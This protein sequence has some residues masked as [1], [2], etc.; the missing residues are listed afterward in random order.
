MARVT[1]EE[2]DR[3]R[4]QAK[5]RQRRNAQAKAQSKQE[6]AVGV[7]PKVTGGSMF[8]Y[9]HKERKR[10]E[11]IKKRRHENGQRLL[12]QVKKMGALKIDADSN[13]FNN[14]VRDVKNAAKNDDG[15]Y[16]WQMTGEGFLIA[17]QK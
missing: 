14:N 7:P 4:R 5:M 13:H 15:R 2:N 17:V 8:G 12:T 16:V 9:I 3:M 6:N 11:Q 1:A 10:H